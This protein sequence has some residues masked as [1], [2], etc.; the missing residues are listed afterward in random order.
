M[1]RTADHGYGAS[2][3]RRRKREA[4][5]VEAGKA[6]CWRCGQPIKL[7]PSGEPEPWDLGHD[8]NDRTKY[9]GPEHQGCNRATKG[10]RTTIIVDTSR[11]W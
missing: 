8:D 4:K 6:I 5:L 1:A 3:Q 10:H 9:M 2:H 7:L 11:E